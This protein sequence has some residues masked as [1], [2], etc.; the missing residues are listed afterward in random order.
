MLITILILLFLAASFF[1]GLR[2][3]FILQFVSLVSFLLALVI[4]F[5]F[6][7]DT[8]AW[9]RQWVPYPGFLQDSGSQ[10]VQFLS[11][12]FDMQTFFY[13]AIAFIALF[14]IAKIVMQMLGSI[15]NVI[16]SVP[17]VSMLN[18]WLGGALA[19]VET[20]VVLFILLVAFSLVPVD[21]IQQAIAQSGLAQF[22][23]YETPYLSQWLQNLGVQGY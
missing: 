16:S 5:Y 14:I 23:I 10:N 3:G 19:V 2:K 1:S 7:E 6:Y 15:F 20:Y 22:M 4:A 8:A 12:T 13:S 17:L 21:P 11:A 18:K 9:L